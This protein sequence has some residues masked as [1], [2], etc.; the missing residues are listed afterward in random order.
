MESNSSVVQKQRSASGFVV[1][2]MVLSLPGCPVLM[3]TAIVWSSRQ[4]DL[5]AL[6]DSDI[7]LQELMTQ[8]FYPEPT[9]V[10]PLRGLYSRSR[11]LKGLW[12]R[13]S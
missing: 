11:T 3:S 7:A 5:L 6:L 2:Q 13:K 9:G 12:Q 4:V 1:S 8:F 10:L